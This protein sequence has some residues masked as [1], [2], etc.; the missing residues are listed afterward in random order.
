MDMQ[1]A[2][3]RFAKGSFIP[4]ENIQ[5]LRDIHRY[6]KKLVGTVASEKNRI[7]RV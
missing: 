3:K 5:A 6:K 1:V 7:I 2:N 4:P